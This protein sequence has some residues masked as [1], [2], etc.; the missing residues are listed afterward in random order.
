MS[1]EDI[2]GIRRIQ[3][4]FCQYLDDGNLEGT[5]ELFTDDA[6]IIWVA[7]PITASKSS[8]LPRELLRVDA[9]G[10]PVGAY[11]LGWRLP[12]QR[13]RRPAKAVPT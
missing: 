8:A 7:R 5:I 13:R 4:L 10:Q 3:A 9:P 2:E 6:K 1:V 11:H 12:L